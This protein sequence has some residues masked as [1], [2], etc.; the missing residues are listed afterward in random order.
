MFPKGIQEK[1]TKE[2]THDPSLKV[3]LES[4]VILQVKQLEFAALLPSL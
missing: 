1:L 2:D 3:A 4:F